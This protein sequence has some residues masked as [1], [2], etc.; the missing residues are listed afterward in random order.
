MRIF[1]SRV[2]YQSFANKALQQAEEGL[3][4]LNPSPPPGRTRQIFPL[5]GGQNWGERTAIVNPHRKFLPKGGYL[6]HRHPMELDTPGTG[7]CPSHPPLGDVQMPLRP[8]PWQTLSVGDAKGREEPVDIW[9][10][11]NKALGH[12]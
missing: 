4:G 9:K 7:S 12:L 5:W 10:A 1:L 3:T 2:L 6:Q 11:A 8:L